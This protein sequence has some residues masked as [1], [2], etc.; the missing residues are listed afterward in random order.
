MPHL[1]THPSLHSVDKLVVPKEMRKDQKFEIECQNVYARNFRAGFAM[2]MN[3]FV[4]KRSINWKPLCCAAFSLKSQCVHV[5]D[6]KCMKMRDERR[7][8]IIIL[9]NKISLTCCISADKSL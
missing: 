6:K 4:T 8:E 7:N 2:K 9:K 1:P 5:S 3:K